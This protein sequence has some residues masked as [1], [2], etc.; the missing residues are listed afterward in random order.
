MEDGYYN[1]E[2]NIH[3][4]GTNKITRENRGQPKQRKRKIRRGGGMKIGK[5]RM[6]NENRKRR[7]RQRGVK[8]LKGMRK[9]NRDIAG[10]YE[11]RRKRSNIHRYYELK[12][13]H[14]KTQT[15][16]R[17]RQSLGYIGLIEIM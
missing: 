15:K 5:G 7:G 16:T 11:T 3:Y 8:G 6:E 13:K 9:R 2:G 17:K 1:R 12:R 4:T 14:E 10:N